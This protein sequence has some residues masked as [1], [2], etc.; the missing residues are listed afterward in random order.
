MA[1]SFRKEKKQFSAQVIPWNI[2]IQEGRLSEGGLYTGQ[3]AFL[4]CPSGKEMFF[5]AFRSF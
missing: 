4:D 1:F 3:N 5:D 2:V